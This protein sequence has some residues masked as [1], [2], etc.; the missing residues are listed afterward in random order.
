[1]IRSTRRDTRPM[2]KMCPYCAGEIEPTYKD[3]KSLSRYMTEKGKIVSRSKTGI[4]NK[5]QGR[6]SVA[7]KRARQLA[8]LPF[9][10]VIQ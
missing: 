5:H 10:T 6:M 7:I 8:L 4:C 1:M 3:A 2:N 9:V